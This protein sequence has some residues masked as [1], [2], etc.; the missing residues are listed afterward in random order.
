MKRIAVLTSGGDSPGMNACI[1]AVVRQALAMGIDPYGVRRG[2][3]GL[4]DQE[5]VPM[6][7]RSVG[8]IM[9]HGG[10]ALLTAR[11]QRFRMPAVR[12]EAVQGLRDHGIEGL[13]VIGGNGSFQ[14]ALK[15]AELGIPTI[16]V[17]ASIDNDIGGTDMAIG[18][19]TC[20]NTILDS[21]D[22]IKDTAGS[23]PRPFLIEVMGRH[24]GYLA[25]LAG[26]AG[27]A[28]LVV[29]PEQKMTLE[30]V[31]SEVESA[32]HRG[33][34]LFI[35][36]IAEG[37]AVRAADVCEYLKTRYPVEGAGPRLTI[38][39]HVQRG[40]SPSAF[41]RILATR[42]GVAAVKA[43]AAGESSV[44]VGIRSGVVG[45][46]PLVESLATCPTLDPDLFEMSR[47]LAA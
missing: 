29:T 2:F 16:G 15:V 31:A 19:D 28:E 22:K 41:D 24:S 36:L 13:I 42:L 4:I 3:E 6:T 30:E 23:S 33:K 34:P 32:Y 44:M 26:I 9:R 37:A 5:I 47:A 20:L 18:V 11:S 43:L 7:S 27:G 17:P 46:T 8:S 39:G 21:V 14:G 40:G 1:R 38:L 35:A 45:T 12:T 25:L 10:T